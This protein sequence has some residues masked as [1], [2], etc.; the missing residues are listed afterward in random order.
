MRFAGAPMEITPAAFAMKTALYL[1]ISSEWQPAKFLLAEEVVHAS[2]SSV[3]LPWW[4]TAESSAMV[5]SLSSSFKAEEKL[6]SRRSVK[7]NISQRLRLYRVQRWVATWRPLIAAQNHPHTL[8][9]NQ[10]HTLCTMFRRHPFK[11]QPSNTGGHVGHS[12][13]TCHLVKILYSWKI[14]LLIMFTC[15]QTLL[16]TR[17][18]GYLIEP[19]TNVNWELQCT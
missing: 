15:L 2:S 9:W 17:T 19:F 11:A 7:K 6:P 3:E 18:I 4:G 8:T 5:G 1:I 12:C 13:N 14:S 10:F 16:L